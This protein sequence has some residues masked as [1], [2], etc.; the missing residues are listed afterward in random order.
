MKLPQKCAISMQSATLANSVSPSLNTKKRP[1]FFGGGQVALVLSCCESFFGG[2]TA[3]EPSVRERASGG[4][5]AALRPLRTRRGSHSHGETWHPGPPNCFPSTEGARCWCAPE[6]AW[7]LGIGP[8]RFDGSIAQ[9]DEVHAVDG[10]L[11]FGNQV[12]LDRLSQ[13]LRVLDT[14]APAPGACASISTM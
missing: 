9:G 8:G 10:N 5:C 1:P 2:Q 14:N 13:L 7:Y 4:G 12:A 3:G 6:P 11:M